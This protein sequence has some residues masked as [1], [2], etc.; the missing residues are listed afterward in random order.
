MK[1]LDD[2]LF[3]HDIS[4]IVVH[5]W[6]FFDKGKA[7]LKLIKSFKNKIMELHNSDNYKI[8]N[9]NELATLI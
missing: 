8:I 4:V 5:H 2:Y 3:K 1:I 6:E 9:F 7:N